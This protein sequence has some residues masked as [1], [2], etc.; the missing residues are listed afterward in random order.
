MWSSVTD[1]AIGTAGVALGVQYTKVTLQ[2]LWQAVSALFAGDTE[3]AKD[4]VAGPVG[5]FFVLQASADQ[6]IRLVLMVIALI[7][8]TLAVIN[9]LPI[10]ALDG[11]RLALTL[12][13]RKILKKPLTKKVEEKIIGISMLG[14]LA[15]MVLVTIVDIQ[16]FLL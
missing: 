9:L 15:L 14:L 16:R 11:G 8:L 5:I 10:P 13:F 1:C 2:G 4:S 6:G 12:L 7:S 3:V